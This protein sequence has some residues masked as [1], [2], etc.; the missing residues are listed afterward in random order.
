MKWYEKEDLT[1]SQ[2]GFCKRA[3]AL[4][5]SA[6]CVPCDASLSSGSR[7]QGGLN[8]VIQ[9]MEYYCAASTGVTPRAEL[10][11]LEQKAVRTKM[12]FLNKTFDEPPRKSRR[13]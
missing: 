1:P 9:A 11:K 4:R 6:C 3:V 5:S 2:A 8:A 10:E 7:G 13:K 12:R